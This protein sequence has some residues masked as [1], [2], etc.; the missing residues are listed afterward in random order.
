[1][2]MQFVRVQQYRQVILNRQTGLY[3]HFGTQLQ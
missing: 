3:N 1:M 2:P